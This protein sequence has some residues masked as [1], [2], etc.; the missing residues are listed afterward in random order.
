MI[1]REGKRLYGRTDER[2]TLLSEIVRIFVRGKKAKCSH[3]VWNYE[4]ESA[5]EGQWKNI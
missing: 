1:E 3:T 5:R 2:S 4:R